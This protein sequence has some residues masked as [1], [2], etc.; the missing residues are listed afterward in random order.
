MTLAFWNLLLDL[1]KDYL[2]E[3]Q[4]N[5]NSLRENNAPG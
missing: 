1:E 2:V 4:N 5:R 3:S